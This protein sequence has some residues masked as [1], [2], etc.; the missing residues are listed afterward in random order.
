MEP[1]DRLES[2]KAI[3]A[4]LSRDVR[5]VQRWE[6]EEGLPVH[7]HQHK[8]RGSVYALRPELDA[9]R[10]ARDKVTPPSAD[11][12][13]GWRLPVISAG[14]VAASLT[15]FVFL[16]SWPTMRGAPPGPAP[17]RVRLFG[18]VAREGGAFDVLRLDG[19]VRDVA[20][21]ASGRLL[22][23]RACQ[24]T[25]S[26]LVV[27]DPL[28][29]TIQRTVDGLGRC[30]PMVAARDGARAVMADGP[31]LLLVDVLTGAVRRIETPATQI[32]GLALAPDRRMVYVAAVFAGLFRVDMDTGVTQVLSRHP[33]PIQLALAP[34][35]PLLYVNYQCSGPGGRAGH[36]VIE[37]FNTDESRTE[38]A[39]TGLPNVGGDLELSADGAYLWADGSDACH[40]PQYDHVGC[41]DG[42]GSV[43][44]VI[45]T[46]D[47]K[48]IRT[49]R[50][51]G[52]TEFETRLSFFPDGSRIVAGRR[53]TTVLDAATFAEAEVSEMASWSNVVFAPDGQTAFAALGD[54]NT[55]ARIPLATRAAPPPGI[56]A[57]WTADGVSTDS[58]G[59]N[60]LPRVVATYAPGRV[61]LAFRIEERGALRLDRPTNLDLDRGRFAA[62]AWIRLD[63]GVQG[64]YGPVIEYAA[65]DSEVAFAWRLSVDADRHPVACFGRQR[66]APCGAQGDVLIRGRTSLGVAE[67]HHLAVVRYDD[68]LVLYVD[69]QQQGVTGGLIGGTSSLGALW[70][71]V[72]SSEAGG[73]SF[74]G[75]IDEVELYGR[76]LGPEEV[77]ARAK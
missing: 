27:V 34:V 20:M 19:A 67:W 46:A 1:A 24:A 17:D 15:A 28:A 72:G 74:G 58:A 41:P 77:R 35:G 54:S 75:L 60:D 43:L 23:A 68:E 39:L 57:R 64:P 52:V 5:T 38:S 76:S 18:D 11:A 62:G 37:V 29:W 25:T 45:R 2:W 7:R 56:T 69:G 53:Q 71:R 8:A 6:A 66:N 50:V 33:C 4:Y 59:G 44:N 48:H 26:T 63:P 13:T 55:L 70:L 73:G 22:V 9:W 30:G 12:A 16:S 42:P 36:D 65:Q 10:T 14:L 40:A 49:V 32:R 61:G 3:A 51:G 47:R 31:D 21:A